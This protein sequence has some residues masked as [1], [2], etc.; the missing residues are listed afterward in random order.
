MTRLLLVLVIG[1]FDSWNAFFFSGC[2]DKRAQSTHSHLALLLRRP[3]NEMLE[4]S[5]YC[6]DTLSL[7]TTTGTPFSRQSPTQDDI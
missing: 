3:S 7:H 5:Y 4:T 2:A 1:G 6:D